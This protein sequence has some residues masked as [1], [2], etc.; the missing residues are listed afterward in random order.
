V[1]RLALKTLGCKVNQAEARQMLA[2][3]ASTFNL[4][5]FKAAADFYVINT[6]SVTSEAESKA[7]QLVRQARKRNPQATIVLTG[8]FRAETKELW[9]S[10]GVTLILPNSQKHN[11]TTELKEKFALKISN[12]K[13]QNE[14]ALPKTRAFVKVQ[15]GCDQFCSYCLIPFLRSIK[16]SKPPKDV[17]NEVNKLVTAGCQEVV[18]CGINLGKYGE[19]LPDKPALT[20]LIKAVLK[21]TNISRVRLSSL[22][23]EDINEPLI[24]LLK[25]EPRVAKHLHLSL[26]SGSDRILQLMR[27]RYT[28]KDFLAKVNLIKTELPEIGITCDLIVGFP[29]ET[30]TDFQQSMALLTEIKPLKTHIFKFSARPGSLAAKM[31]DKVSP[32]VKKERLQRAKQHAQYVAQTAKSQ[33]IGKTL[34]VLLEKKE[35]GY[36]TGFSSQYLKVII[37]EANLPLNHLLKAKAVKLQN[38]ALLAKSEKAN[39]LLPSKV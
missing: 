22:N 28:A 2:D 36:Y 18:L 32:A 12:A 26:Q 15:D 31:P 33:F 8:C 16:K 19:D 14:Q 29:G 13:Q 25:E 9:R 6:C 27:R 37:P 1:T 11:L 38:E 20:T 35:N 10:L 3:L 21:E 5:N 7:R 39:N 30:E 23:I 17:I 34:E 24:A 4:V